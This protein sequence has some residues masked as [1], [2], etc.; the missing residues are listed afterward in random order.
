[1]EQLLDFV[2]PEP[3]GSVSRAA[4]AL[5]NPIVCSQVPSVTLRTLSV[6]H[7]PL[8]VN[9]QLMSARHSTVNQGSLSRSFYQKQTDF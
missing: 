9:R 2:T 1:M 3:Q 8:S 7:Q 4:S 5:V 6:S